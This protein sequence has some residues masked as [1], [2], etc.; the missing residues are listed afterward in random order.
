MTPPS[1]EMP[2][3]IGGKPCIWMTW[4]GDNRMPGYLELCLQTVRQQN[5]DLFN[6][7]VITPSNLHEYFSDLHPAYPFLSYTHRSDYLRCQLL[8]RYG[9]VYLDMDTL[10]FKPLWPWYPRLQHFELV[11]YTGAPWGEIFGVGI[12]GPTRRSSL[13]TTEW[14][15]RLN[16]LM[17]LRQDELA[18]YRRRNRRHPERDCLGWSELLRDIVLP[19]SQT[20]QEQ[21][22]LSF[23]PVGLDEFTALSELYSIEQLFSPYRDL[24][25]PDS[26]A[27][28][29]MNNA[30]Y[31]EWFK[32][33]SREKVLRSN[34]GLVSILRAAVQL[35][36]AANRALDSTPRQP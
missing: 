17:D 30:L 2:I 35:Q 4:T 16:A 27:L 19:L 1:G 3:E 33:L 21:G 11:S 29:I 20:L 14:S 28:L 31:P 34:C 12:F 23:A 22:R 26:S 13:L 8:H 18:Q 6:V 25:I 32:R 5:A 9:G 36:Q 24:R 10:C 15:Q 7:I